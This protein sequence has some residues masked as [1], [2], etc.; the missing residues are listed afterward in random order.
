MV[1]FGLSQF[2]PGERALFFLRGKP[3]AAG[4]VG[5]AQGKRPMR[6]ETT[7]GKWMIDRADHS[8]LS[9]VPMRTPASGV[10]TPSPIIDDAAGP[11]SLDDMR[12]RIRTILK[13]R[14]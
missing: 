7:T 10:V 3:T 4:I 9:R 14:Q 1:V 6:L 11:Q 5:M 8:G 12:E 2:V 13:V